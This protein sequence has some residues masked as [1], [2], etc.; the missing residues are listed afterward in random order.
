VLSH[1]GVV[2]WQIEPFGEQTWPGGQVPLQVGA[3]AASHGV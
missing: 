3:V 2:H 1:T